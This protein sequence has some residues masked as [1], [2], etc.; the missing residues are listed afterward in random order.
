MQRLNGDRTRDHL[1]A[2]SFENSCSL[3]IKLKNLSNDRIKIS[4]K[5]EFTQSY[6][7]S[8]VNVYS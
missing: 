3:A 5:N 7:F 6:D 2:K 4:S 1:L 8:Q